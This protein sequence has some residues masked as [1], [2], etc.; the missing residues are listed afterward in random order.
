LPRDPETLQ[1]R[2]GRTGRA[3]RKGVAVLVVPYTRRKQVEWVL[4]NASINA[5]WTKPPTPEDIRRSD[6]DRLLATLL[7]PVEIEDDER[8][9][10]D[11]LLAQKSPDEIAIALVRAHRERLPAPEDLVDSGV[12]GRDA[13]RPADGRQAG[14]ED[15]V[16][17]RMSVGRRDNADPRWLLPMLCRRGHVTKNE[18]GTI[19]IAA[20]ETTFEIPRAVARRFMQAVE[21]TATGEDGEGG[22]RIEPLGEAPRHAGPAR[23]KAG[24]SHQKG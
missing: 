4:R 10:V 3:G 22:V 21:R 18:I 24:P 17:F 19:R 2:S 13:P 23:R 20:E 6:R 16:W 5:E 8:E 11:R 14:F 7:A 9:L 15:A 1:H 12:G